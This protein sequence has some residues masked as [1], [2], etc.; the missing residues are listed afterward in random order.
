MK[1]A[2]FLSMVTVATMA[3]QNR[4]GLT[5]Y[6]GDRVQA[7]RQLG[8]ASISLKNGGQ[9]HSDITILFEEHYDADLAHILHKY[10]RV[11]TCKPVSEIKSWS[12]PVCGPDVHNV[13][14]VQDMERDLLAFFSVNATSQSIVVA[15]RG[16]QSV[17]NY[18]TDASFWAKTS[19]VP[20]CE[21]CRVHTGFFEG[22]HAVLASKLREPLK[23][24]I[25]ANPTFSVT[26][27]GH[28][29]GAAVSVHHALD[30]VANYTT[31]ER[32]QLYTM[33]EPGVGNAAFMRLLESQ[34]PLGHRW[35]IVNQHDIVPH[36][37]PASWVLNYSQ[38]GPE[39]WYEHTTDLQPKI[40]QDGG[41][42]A[43]SASV[44]FY[45]WTPLDHCPY[46]GKSICK[47]KV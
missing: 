16:S 25:R 39:V 14:V 2:L 26:V 45:K 27:M 12:C 18:I 33:G 42:R 5:R 8:A 28:S 10:E 22:Y 36:I 3:S 32:V 30:L 23:S 13:T 19:A 44:P 11:T 47:C 40:C 20:G 29:L 9:Q 46:L 24:T 38:W 37:P 1:S 4:E 7:N 41:D 43:C 15:F 17:R 34:I 21:A 31:N 35:R 6:V